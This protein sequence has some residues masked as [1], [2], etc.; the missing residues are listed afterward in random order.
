M[1]KIK[2]TLNGNHLL[3][4]YA[5]NSRGIKRTQLQRVILF[6]AFAYILL[7]YIS[8][9]IGLP[10]MFTS[11]SI[12]LLIGVAGFYCYCNMTIK[13]VYYFEWGVLFLTLAVLS[14]VYCPSPS[15]ANGEIY[16]LI[17]SF[18]LTACI[19]QGVYDYSDIEKVMR[20]FFIA[21]FAIS[22]ISLLLYRDMLFSS[23]RFGTEIVGNPNALMLILNFPVNI[24]IYR[25]FIANKYKM[26]YFCMLAICV[27][28]LLFTG[29]KKG[30]FIPLIFMLLYMI[31][32][33]K[34]KKKARTLV[35]I[36]IVIYSLYYLIFNVPEL[37]TVIGSRVEELFATYFGTGQ[38][39]SKS[40]MSR[41]MMIKD[42]FKMFLDSP[43]WGHGINAFAV[44]GGY[45]HY[46]HNNYIEIL[47]ALGLIGSIT[48]YSIYVYCLK[49]LFWIRKLNKDTDGMCSFFIAMLICNMI[50][51][52]GAVSYNIFI[53]HM[54]IGL[55]VSYIQIKKQEINIRSKEQRQ[56]AIVNES[57][58]KVDVLV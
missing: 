41:I 22:A 38:I 37:Y 15:S 6:A 21:A 54:S 9:F 33:K 19:I 58:K 34:N 25:C 45:G 49:K 4:M 31:L 17:T 7:S 2:Y 43:L 29:S 23:D 13:Y 44:T 10:S 14:I 16:S 48:Y 51:D 26:I 53:I 39:I 55:A 24:L 20:Y 27:T 36:S 50:F 42:G 8:N 57:V 11:L 30:L 5:K 12:Y 46:S 28:V 40:D 47:S 3:M 56:N 1:Q 18:L 52:W 35:T 32:S